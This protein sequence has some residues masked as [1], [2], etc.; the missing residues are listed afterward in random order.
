MLKKIKY[1]FKKEIPILMYHRIIDS[2]Q[3]FHIFKCRG[4]C[5]TITIL[6]K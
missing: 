6:K 2:E 3:E 1:Y 5:K 4:I